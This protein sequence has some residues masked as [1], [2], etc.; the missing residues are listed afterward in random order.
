MPCLACPETIGFDDVLCPCCAEE[1][2][3]T[4]ESGTVCA[5]C[6]DVTIHLRC[7]NDT[8]KALYDSEKEWICPTCKYHGKF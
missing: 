4:V 7:M 1:N 6:E 5:I 2:S 3:I 8:D